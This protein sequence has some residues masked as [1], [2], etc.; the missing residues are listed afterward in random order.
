MTDILNNTYPFSKSLRLFNDLTNTEKEAML[1][2]SQKMTYKKNEVIFEQDQPGDLMFFI[3]K[4]H[5][6]LGRTDFSGK[7]LT[8]AIMGP[9]EFFGEIALMNNCGRSASA[10]ALS[11]V[12]LLAVCRADFTDLLLKYPHFALKVIAILCS[13]LLVTDQRIEE[14]AFGS[15]KERLVSLLMMDGD[16]SQKRILLEQT[17]QEL[18][19]KVGA[20]RETVTRVL[21][22]LKNEGWQIEKISKKE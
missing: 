20:S 22:S 12:V 4:G 17:H 7:E 2:L 8:L 15:I 11:D 16:G 1:A 3:E 10:Y 19:A 14:I 13:R 18:A 9:H 5:V 6:K 21:K